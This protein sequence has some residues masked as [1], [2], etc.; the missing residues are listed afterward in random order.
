[1]LKDYFINILKSL[2]KSLSIF[3]YKNSYSYDSY[4]I[5]VVFMIPISSKNKYYV[6]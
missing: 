5:I 3:Y 6:F 4:S 2:W 1:M